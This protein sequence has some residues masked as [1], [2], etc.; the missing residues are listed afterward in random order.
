MSNDASDLIAARAGDAEAFARVY[1]RHAGVVLAVCRRC[2]SLA[3]AEDAMQDTFLRAYRKL[4]QLSRPEGFRP[5]LYAIARRV[6]A[7]RRRTTQRR[8]QRETRAVRQNAAALPE[9]VP[10]ADVLERAEDLDRLTLALDHLP[11]PERLAIHLYYLD[12]EP[13]SAARDAL[14][15]SRSGFYKLLHRARRRLAS[16]MR[17]AQPT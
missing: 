10:P 1:E 17:E 11:E 14:G 5:W 7:E 8:R 6:C 9:P 16:L 15:V 3:D 2:S 4:D 12:P 13:V